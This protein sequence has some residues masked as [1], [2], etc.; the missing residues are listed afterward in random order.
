MR[1]ARRH[2]SDLITAQEIACWAYCPEQW[3]LQYGQR[4]PPANQA[5]MDAGTR[6]HEQKAV[7]EQVAGGSIALGRLLAILAVVVLLVVLWWRS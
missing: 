7:V 4:L 6:H 2:S 3:R 1:R 5:A